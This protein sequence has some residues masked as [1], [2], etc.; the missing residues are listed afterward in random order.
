MATESEILERLIEYLK[1]MAPDGVELSA[2][3]HIVTTLALDSV[4]VLDIV[5]DIED[6]F[7][8]VVPMEAL[9]DVHTVG[10]LVKVVHERIR[11]G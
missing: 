5:L 9:V 10:D 8:A 4:K 7:D 11:S 2:E 1:P 3:T 6:D